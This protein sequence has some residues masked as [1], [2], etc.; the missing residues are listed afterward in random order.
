MI[1]LLLLLSRI[2]KAIFAWCYI[3]HKMAIIYN[4]AAFIVARSI[5]CLRIYRT[6]V[7]FGRILDPWN[8]LTYYLVSRKKGYTT[9][10][11]G[12]KIC[13]L[14]VLCGRWCVHSSNI[15]KYKVICSISIQTLKIMSFWYQWVT[16][17]RFTALWIWILF[18]NFKCYPKME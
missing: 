9:S 10:K 18:L 3:N 16:N 4:H 11:R 15:N 14:P 8:T 2:I 12:M 7:C 17:L 5:R 6:I 13:I 1:S